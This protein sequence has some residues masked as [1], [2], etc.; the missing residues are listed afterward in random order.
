MKYVNI[1]VS[2]GALIGLVGC[3]S[4]VKVAVLE[5]VGPAP[6]GR[7][8]GSSI[9]CLQVFSARQPAVIDLNMEERA[10]NSD[11][12]KNEFEYAQGHTAYTIYNEAGRLVKRVR[13]ARNQDDPEPTLVP[14]PAGCY[15]IRAEAEARAGTVAVSIPVVIRP[16]RITTAHLAGGWKP[17]GHYTDNEVVRLPDGAIAGWLA[18]R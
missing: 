5:P 4:P 9:G 2:T 14:L 6:T 18:T 10:W 13:N 7:L 16:G 3:A 11:F 8:Q 15:E 17:R 1:I 12:G